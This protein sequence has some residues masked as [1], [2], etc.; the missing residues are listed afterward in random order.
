PPEYP[1]LVMMIAAW[2]I[3]LAVAEWYIRR[4]ATP[5][6]RPRSRPRPRPARRPGAHPRHPGVLMKAVVQA[7]FGAPDSLR[8]VDADEPRAGAGDVV[9]RVHAA[10]VNPA[11]WHALR[12][13]PYVARLLG[14]VGFRRPRNRVAGHD[15]A[16]RVAVVGPG[17]SGLRVGDEVYG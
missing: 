13:D 3:N 8:L 2:V 5:G 16:G 4:H 15:V 10:A 1:R 12:G 11:D 7:R 9:A 14:I 17:V 6:L